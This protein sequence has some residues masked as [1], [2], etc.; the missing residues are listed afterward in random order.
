MLHEGFRRAR[1]GRGAEAAAA[2][3]NRMIRI[4]DVRSM[5]ESD[6]AAIAGGVPGRELMYRAGE[7]IFRA[8]EWKA[9]AA[10]VCG[11]KPAST[12]P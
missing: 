10:V 4:L 6:A 1:S 3:E 12:G 2:K 9:P 7:G 11:R 8:A 5:R